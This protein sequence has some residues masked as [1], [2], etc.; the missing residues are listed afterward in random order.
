M[1]GP[2]LRPGCNALWRYGVVNRMVGWPA[3][4]VDE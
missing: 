1:L 4:A 2:F 3:C